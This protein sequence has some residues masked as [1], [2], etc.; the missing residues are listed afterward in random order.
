[1]YGFVFYPK[2]TQVCIMSNKA[3][4]HLITPANPQATMHKC[5]LENR[6]KTTRPCCHA[7]KLFPPITACHIYSFFPIS[8]SPCFSAHRRRAHI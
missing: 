3:S 5:S 2:S 1:M 6:E 8:F 7:E 4:L